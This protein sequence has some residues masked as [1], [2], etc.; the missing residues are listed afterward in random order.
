M[1]KIAVVIGRTGKGLFKWLEEHNLT[2]PKTK[3]VAEIIA[4]MIETY[5]RNDTAKRKEIVKRI[6][7]ITNSPPQ[8]AVE[9]VRQFA[10]VADT[11]RTL[12]NLIEEASKK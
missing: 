9:V 5:E 11:Y 1:T 8:L 2:V 4:A 6:L 12:L 10:R 3:D 7:E